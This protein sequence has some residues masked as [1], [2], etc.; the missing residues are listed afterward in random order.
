M[1]RFGCGILVALACEVASGQPEPQRNEFE[2]ASVKP[3]PPPV[4]G[5]LMVR[6]SGGPGRPD[7]TLFTC[8]NCSL[9]NLITIAYGIQHYQLSGVDWLQ[10]SMFDVNAKVPKGATQDQFKL[11]L[12]SLLADRFKLAVHHESKDLPVYELVVAKG[13]RSSRSRWRTSRPR[14]TRRTQRHPAHPRRRPPSS[15]RTDIR[16]WRL[17]VRG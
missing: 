2:V 4:G 12:Q 10:A 16:N 9:S 5:M 6:M 8:E 7:P 17:A 15:V 1:R 3:S 13:G 14:T 11:M